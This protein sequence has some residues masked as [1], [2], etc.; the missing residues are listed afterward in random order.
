MWVI[1]TLL[2]LIYSIVTTDGF[3]ST[4]MLWAK[5]Q[6]SEAKARCQ[7]GI[8]RTAQSRV[9][10][11]REIA[12]SMGG[13]DIVD[14]SEDEEE[15]VEDA[16]TDSATAEPEETRTDEE[17]GTTHGY[18]GDFKVGDVVRV[19]DDI[20]IWSVKQYSDEGFSCQGFE[21]K[22]VQL[23]LYG[24]KLKSLCSAI[25]PVKVDFEPTGNGVPEGMFTRKFTAHFAGDELDLVTAA[26]ETGTS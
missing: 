10:S 4:A 12:L 15:D 19:K 3:T 7:L 5:H 11:G 25:T 13:V 17:L 6:G 1:G 14:F 8:Y 2:A 21:G 20:R 23:V 26:S 16:D 22:V 9:M 24:R 18:E